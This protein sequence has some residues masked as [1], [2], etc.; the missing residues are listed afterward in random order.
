MSDSTTKQDPHPIL[1]SF[2]SSA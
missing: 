1:T 2:Q